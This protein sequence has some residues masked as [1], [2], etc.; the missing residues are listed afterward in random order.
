M[1]TSPSP[2]R[3]L[4][5][6]L[7]AQ[8]GVAAVQQGFAI[9]APFVAASMGA[10]LVAAG[11]LVT[12]FTVGMAIMN[13]PAGW[14]LDRYGVSIV[15][16]I[17][18]I[19]MTI[20]LL[21][22]AIVQPHAYVL[23]FALFLLFGL[24]YPSVPMSGAKVVFVAFTGK[25]RSTAMGI[26]QTGVP[27]GGALA[28]A[29][30]PT[31]VVSYGLDTVFW[32]LAGLIAIPGIWFARSIRTLPLPSA[33]VRERH[34]QGMG[35]YRGALLPGAIGF[36]LAAGQYCLITFAIPTLRHAG[37]SLLLASL[38]LTLVQAGGLAGRIVFG[39]ISERF[40]RP[41]SL[42]LVTGM[43]AVGFLLFPVLQH[44]VLPVS[45]GLWLLLGLG[46]VGW[47]ALLLTWAGERVSAQDAGVAFGVAA[48]FIFVGAAIFPV[49][50]G[51]VAGPLGLQR[52]W[53]GVAVLYAIATVAIVVSVLQ[54]RARSLPS[55]HPVGQAL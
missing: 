23:A 9:L 20:T 35:R 14:L 1:E 22:L 26:R 37:F 5:A 10:G 31:L 13:I 50:F 48:A 53:D 15:S 47:N 7:T 32:L 46:G 38:G 36:L 41:Q 44:P 4:L 51:A 24:A 16:R 52:P 21:V 34:P 45:L 27:I 39:A 42:A 8:T 55:T 2:N 3:L 11:G 18:L 28:A 17:G 49:L 19:S 54:A 33:S 29:L 30:F 25:R 6:S 43:G 40:G 12:A